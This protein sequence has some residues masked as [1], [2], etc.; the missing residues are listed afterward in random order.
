VDIIYQLD[1]RRKKLLALC[2][3]WQLSLHIIPLWAGGNEECQT[4]ESWG[5][6]LEELLTGSDVDSLVTEVPD[7]GQQEW[8][9]SGN[10]EQSDDEGSESD[11]ALASDEEGLL[12]SIA[13]TEFYDEHSSI[14]DFED[15]EI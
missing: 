6:R 15:C 4:S 12:E 13:F 10:E 9:N 11:N 5:P 8:P 3:R 7:T 1:L 14:V 2:R